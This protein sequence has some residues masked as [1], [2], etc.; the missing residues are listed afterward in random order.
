MDHHWCFSGS[1][2]MLIES[3]VLCAAK[4]Q[5]HREG[6]YP[7]LQSPS[8]IKPDTTSNQGAQ[9]GVTAVRTHLDLNSVLE[10]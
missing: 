5:Q 7:K 8:G 4:T 3:G 6:S 10:L 2:Q 9:Y 1:S